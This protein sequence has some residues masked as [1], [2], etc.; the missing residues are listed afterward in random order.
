MTKKKED[1][2]GILGDFID[3]FVEKR[4]SEGA[5]SQ[6]IEAESGS[7]IKQLQKRLYQS[8]LQGE[9]SDHLGYKKG[10]EPPTE[11]RRNGTSKKTLLSD[12]GKVE[13]DVP[14][15]RQG[16]FEPQLIEK[17]QKRVPTFNDK[18]I[19][20]YS[21][22][23]SQRQIQDQLEDLYGCSVSQD[24]ISNV[25]DAVLDDVKEWRNRPLDKVY[26]IVYLDALVTKVRGDSGVINHAVYVAM[27]VNLEGKKEVLG[28]WMSEN[29]GA[30]FWLRVLTE[31]KNRG[32]EDIFIACVDGLTG[33]VEAIESA[34]PKTLVQGCIVHAVRNSLK[35]VGWKERKEV[36][37]DLK[38]IYTS[39]TREEA[40]RELAVFREK[41]DDKHPLIGLQ[42]ERDWQKLS[43]FFDY[44]AEIR[45]A[46]YTTNAIES[47]NH[48]LRK[49]L[50]N[51][52]SFPSEEAL[53]KILY[54]ALQR[55]GDPLWLTSQL[56]L[57]NVS[58]NS[59]KSISPRR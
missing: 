20:L 45:R 31:L 44:P 51:K 52:K 2:L 13:I 46:I 35:L 39:T 38:K 22:G 49:V 55:A 36:A 12:Q 5:S 29:E 56:S 40:E 10:A 18:V 43:V 24:L 37:T 58:Q 9:M 23:L 7:L 16:K 50:K 6:Q 25:T 54:L 21:Q 8:V 11:N 42:W 41:W 28:L 17:N 26:P 27:G 47:L 33:F 4:Q 32:L 48:S 14:R 30:K 15:D 57:A 19:Y 59:I 3:E 34:Y 1:Q 53:M